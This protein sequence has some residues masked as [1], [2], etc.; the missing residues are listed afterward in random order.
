MLNIKIT[1]YLRTLVST[2]S[3]ISDC[4]KVKAYISIKF[5]LKC[6]H[7]VFGSS[8]DMDIYENVKQMALSNTKENGSYL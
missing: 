3:P 4:D 2:G 5:L 6:Q 8:L 7:K 1:S